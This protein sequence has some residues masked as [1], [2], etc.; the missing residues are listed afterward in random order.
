[1]R[2]WLTAVVVAL[3]LLVAGPTSTASADDGALTVR[4][5]ALTPS[6]LDADATIRMRGTIRNTG[7]TP[8]TAVQAYLVIPR[9]PF[10][11]REQI[12]TAIEDGQSYTGERIVDPG[13]FDEVGDIAPGASVTFDIAVPVSRIGLAGEGGVYPVGVQILATDA[14]GFRSTDSVARATTFVPWL[15]RPDTA[16]PAG[17]VWPFTPTWSA[18]SFDPT[19]VVASITSGQLRNYLDAATAT[20]RGGRTVV[21]DLS[22]LDT[23]EPLSDPETVPAGVSLTPEQIDAVATWLGR[24]R[25]LALDSTTWIVSYARA[26]ELAL[27]RYPENAEVLL[28]RIDAATTRAMTRHSLTGTRANWPTISGLT[29][30]MLEEMR[31]RGDHPTFVSR[32]S[33]PEWE[34]RLGSVVTVETGNGPIP[35]LVNGTL[36]DT[37]GAE[38]AVTVR[39]RVLTDAALGVLSRETDP[40]SRAD[41]LTVIDPSWNPG[42]NGGRVLTQALVGR[43]SAGLTRPVTAAD[44]LRG[45]PVTYTGEIPRDVTTTS[46]PAQLLDRAA[47]LSRTADLFTEIVTDEDD[48]MFDR[49]V[50]G[51]LSVRWRSDADEALRR[52]ES[53][54]DDLNRQLAGLSIESPSTI[55]LS[56]SRGGFPLTIV[57]DTGHRARLGLTLTADNPY[58]TLEQVDPIE[59]EPGERH[60]VTVTVDLDGQSSSTVTATLTTA[61]GEPFGEPVDFNVR[62]SNVGLI[63]WVAMAAAMV[64]VVATWVRRFGRRRRDAVASSTLGDAH[65]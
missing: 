43:P 64:L 10:Q 6:Q 23:L 46:L 15:D 19:A 8:W 52:V 44:L 17:F 55:T 18:A 42:R 40:T 33:V 56:S 41:A 38:T 28:Q 37:P 16:I 45:A 65:E 47:T 13:T 22:L 1:M 7:S 61:D 39:Q 30:G 62:S 2:A 27:H 3:S 60:T 53:R 32:R 54:I 48:L 49:E 14:E 35:L 9:F 21:L 5:D 63:V 26:D 12:E 25:E 20:P 11:S 36:P 58:L 31:A 4:I 29:R 57:N 59:I 24:L 50:S 34:P 51:V